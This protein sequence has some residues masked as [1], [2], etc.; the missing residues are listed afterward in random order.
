MSI[1][2]LTAVKVGTVC[3]GNSV[4]GQH[5]GEDTGVGV[6]VLGGE[7]RRTRVTR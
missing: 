4:G 3:C 6:C 7:V 1:W 5:F 2:E